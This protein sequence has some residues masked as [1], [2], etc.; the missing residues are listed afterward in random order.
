MRALI[1][2]LLVFGLTL[3]AHAK[4]YEA[5]S[6][7]FVIY[8]DDSEDD[9]RTFAENLEK[10]H[11][12]MEYVTQWEMEKPSPSNRVT[13]FVVGSERDLQRL[14]GEGGRNVGGFYTPRAGGSKAFV[15]DIQMKDGYPHFST[16]I[17]LHEYAHHFLISQ[18][19]FAMPRWLS[20]G[21]AEF[22]AATSFNSDGGVSLGR[23]AQ[24]RAGELALSWR[25][26]IED[27][28][29][30]DMEK[31][32][33][34]RGFYGKAWGLYHLLVFS[35]E[36]AGQLRD[37]RRR[38]A[39][40][41]GSL[42]A[43][44]EAFGDLDQLETDLRN[45]L[46][47][48]RMYNFALG[49]E[50]IPIGTVRIRELPEGE[51]EMMPIRIRS[52]RGVDAETAAEVLVDARKV[53]VKYPEDA[54]VLTALAEAEYDAGNDTEAIAAADAA[55][56]LDPGRANAYVQ[57][58]YALF[59]MA[60]EAEDTDTA[61]REAMKPF[62]ALNAIE[63]DHP[64]P[65]I[66]YYR[67]FA[68]RGAEPNATARAALE[69]AAELAPF[70]Q[71]LWMNVAMMQATNGEI[72]KARASLQPV[73]SAPHGRRAAKAA[74]AMLDA[75][76]TWEEGTP[77]DPSDPAYHPQLDEE[78]ADDAEGAGAGAEEETD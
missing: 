74:K 76:Q 17:L 4:W 73:A 15:Q 3:P 66:Y 5:S 51:A 50:R 30:P 54:G 14:Y 31:E 13:I 75:L 57:K 40:G 8:A 47:Q 26:P 36:R 12:A 1:A 39:E 27:L 35:Q 44:Q 25:M 33:L 77:F 7:H 38:M 21:A 34:H 65:L 71:S 45:Y 18:S 6:D 32:G 46:R 62:T 41:A 67:S 55:I 60:Y 68:E 78:T 56:A 22:F 49:P 72:A 9:V 53:A 28:L 64:L 29:E 19:R 61:F 70:D 69:R 10:Y 48:R 58:G 24:H 52:Q 20:E 43:A 23:P 37:Y 2:F 16:V 42:D 59:R 63:N 11:E